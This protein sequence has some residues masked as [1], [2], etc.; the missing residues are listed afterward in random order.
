VKEPALLLTEP[1][2]PSENGNIAKALHFFGVDSQ[3]QT[4]AE[5]LAQADAASSKFR[6]FG[7]SATFLRF[8]DELERNSAG[9]RLWQERV[10]SCFVCAERD[11]DSFQQLARRLTGEARASLVE[12]GR[13]T[14]GWVV[15]DKLVEF[16]GALSGIRAS[17]PNIDATSHLLED[18]AAFA[19]FDHQGVPL[20]LSSSPSVIDMDS[21]LAATNFDVRQHFISAVPLVLYV[22]WAFAQT[23]WNAPEINACLIIDDALLK[24]RYGFVDFQELLALMVQHRFSTNIAFIP[25]NWRRSAANVVRFFNE[26]PEKYS[27]SIHGCDH[28]AAEFGTRDADTLTWKAQQAAD[29][30]LRHEQETGIR[31]DRIMVFPQGV[32]SDVSMS[33]LKR[34]NFTAAVNTEVVSDPRS[35]AMVV[36]DVWDVAV[37]RYSSFPIFTRRYPSQGVENFA[38]D[39][40]LGKPCLIVIH[41]DFC[42][43][44]YT[45]L[46]EFI[47][48]LNALKCPLAWG[49]LGEV[50]TRSC[51]QREIFPGSVEIEM[52]GTELRLENRSDQRK[53]FRITRRE[54]DP[55]V[56]REICAESNSLAWD[57][58]DGRIGFE[59]E[60]DPGEGRT[61]SARFHEFSPNGERAESMSS[62]LKIML[63]RYLSE[64]RD[65]YVTKSPLG[66]RGYFRA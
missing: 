9:L 4:P 58:S 23:C 10:H 20:F 31:H 41:H 35:H 16:C 45:K 56:L 42:R 2:V 30:M 14:G 43:D 29:R 53:R 44:R 57:H 65:N 28:T 60:L 7:S 33:V 8:I 17:A 18:G 39:I 11:A 36:S 21:E 47:D 66:F 61:V 62:R 63:R 22:K 15:S 64:A 40:V 27:L 34:T 5:F 24:P 13:G 12:R 59:I 50:V 54:S 48:S 25:W 3:T 19:R 46:V 1:G 38:F 32:F 55:S 26:H 52:Y 49:S 6:L 37:M 51:R